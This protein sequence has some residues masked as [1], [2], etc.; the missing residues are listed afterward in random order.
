MDSTRT[1]LPAHVIDRAITDTQTEGSGRPERATVTLTE[2]AAYLGIARST[3]YQL[4]S[5][6]RFPVPIIRLGRRVVVSRAALERL[7]SG[8]VA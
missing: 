6:D 7:V 1:E 3:A 2:A 8:E 4:A 5:E